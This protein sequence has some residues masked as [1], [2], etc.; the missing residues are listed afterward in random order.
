[1]D[2]LPSTV[3][4]LAKYDSILDTIKQSSLVRENSISHAGGT[5]GKRAYVHRDFEEAYIII[6]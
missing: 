4:D 2:N 1:M 6:F 5:K 3:D